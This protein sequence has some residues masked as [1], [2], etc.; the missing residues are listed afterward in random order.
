MVRL[1][2]FEQSLTLRIEDEELL[3]SF[4][5]LLSKRIRGVQLHVFTRQKWVKIKFYGGLDEVK[6]SVE[7]ARRLYRELLR[8][9]YPDKAGYYNYNLATLL[10]EANL[11]IAIPP[12]LLVRI[13]H[14]NGY[15]SEVDGTLLRTRAPREVVIKYAEKLS[16]VYYESLRI[17]LTPTARRAVAYYSV[18]KGIEPGNSVENLLKKGILS[19]RRGVLHLT[20]N[21]NEVLEEIDKD[22]GGEC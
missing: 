1:K 19:E 17:P 13:L 9:K 8:S 10:S 6:Y 22:V 20:R 14:Y 16:Q 5:D 7:A 15:R 18:V 11:Q 21:I 12:T 3:K 4:L 2:M